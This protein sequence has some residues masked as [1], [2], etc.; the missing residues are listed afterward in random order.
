MGRL[1]VNKESNNEE[2]KITKCSTQS[3]DS[4][5]WEYKECQFHNTKSTKRCE[6]C[7][8]WKPGSQSVKKHTPDSK[9]EELAL[10]SDSKASASNK[11]DDESNIGL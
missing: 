11:K 5:L 9:S 7:N 4:T 3:K 10:P 1:D 6:V 2:R 8:R